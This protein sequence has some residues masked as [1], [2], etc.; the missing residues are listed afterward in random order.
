M[1]RSMVAGRHRGKE[2]EEGG[3][4]DEGRERREERG[5]LWLGLHTFSNRSTP[6]DPSQNSSTNQ[7]PSIE[8]HESVVAIPA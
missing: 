6:P 8:M 3:R 4:R 7:R 2:G 1:V 5:W